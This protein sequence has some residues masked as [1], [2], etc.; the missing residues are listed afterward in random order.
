MNIYFTLGQKRNTWGNKWKGWSARASGTAF[1]L[2]LAAGLITTHAIVPETASAS[3]VGAI[4]I[5]EF[6]AD[7]TAVTDMNGEWIEIENRSA[8]LVDLYDWDIAVSSSGGSTSSN[9]ISGGIKLEPGERAVV[10]KNMNRAV[11]GGVVC[12][13][14]SNF[15]LAQAEDTTR[16]VR[17]RNRV[18]E[19]ISSIS[20][21]GNRD[22]VAGRS[23]Y[24]QG[25][26]HSSEMTYQ[27]N[28]ADYGTPDHNTILNKNL[29][30]IGVQNT[31]DLNKNG[32]MDFNGET[33]IHNPGWKVRLYDTDWN[34][35]SF[36]DNGSNEVITTDA[37]S[38]RPAIFRV[39]AG[40]YFLCQASQSGKPQ[41]FV[42][43]ITSWVTWDDNGVANNSGNSDEDSRCIAVHSLKANQRGTHKFGNIVESELTRGQVL[44]TAIN[45]MDQDGEPDWND[46]EKHQ[47]GL[48]VRLYD[49]GWQ[50]V[51]TTTTN[52]RPY[53]PAGFTVPLGQYYVCA[54]LPVGYTQSFARIITSWT[55]W[56]LAGVPN[57]SSQSDEGEQCIAV[58][59]TADAT[60]SLLFG[61]VPPS[62]QAEESEGG[63]PSEENTTEPLES[64]EYQESTDQPALSVPTET[65]QSTPEP[66][67]DAT[68]LD[69]SDEPAEADSS[70]PDPTT[71]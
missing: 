65:T 38:S 19:V 3:E 36:G 61:S 59:I 21:V 32:A 15:N 26:T 33:G 28:E 68:S 37:S 69:K 60:P 57:H 42:A 55:T 16:I 31:T 35:A 12:D 54:V 11:N 17:L 66:V 8:A 43:S 1:G 22:V 29:A 27:Y 67:T 44:I 58:T 40:S 18:D 48:E 70:D 25:D 13:G 20:Y 51:N 50:Y 64:T 34:P 49:E 6:M 45:D 41:S 9:V 71:R 10:C 2:L 14:R 46:D 23:T 62:P 47:P 53:F 52:D 7:P 24:V 63:N 30:S 5:T 39:P 56:P 4:V